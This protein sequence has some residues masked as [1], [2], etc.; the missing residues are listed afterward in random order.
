MESSKDN[1]MSPLLPVKINTQ[2]AEDT[3]QVD[4]FEIR[5]NDQ[6]EIGGAAADYILEETN[7][8]VPSNTFTVIDNRNS[9]FLFLSKKRV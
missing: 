7:I 6:P 2:D 8:W 1:S 3:T 4:Q 9:K 5:I